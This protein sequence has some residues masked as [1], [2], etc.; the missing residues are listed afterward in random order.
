MGFDQSIFIDRLSTTGFK[1]AVTYRLFIIYKTEVVVFE[2]EHFKKKTSSY[3]LIL[4]G[5]SSTGSSTVRN[6]GRIFD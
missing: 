6:I 3:I 1:V 4:D 2:P 5:I